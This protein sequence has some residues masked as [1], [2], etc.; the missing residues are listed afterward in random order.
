MQGPKTLERMLV[1]LEVRIV[2]REL[3]L[4]IFLEEI[5]AWLIF[6]EYILDRLIDWVLHVMRH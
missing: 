4:K 1:T 5:R 2:R 3:L 6:N